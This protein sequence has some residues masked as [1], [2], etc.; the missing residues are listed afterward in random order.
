MSVYHQ[1]NSPENM[2]ISYILQTGRLDIYIYIYASKL[3][4]SIKE[5][6]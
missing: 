3:E 6:M 1:M 5:E 4:I 2:N